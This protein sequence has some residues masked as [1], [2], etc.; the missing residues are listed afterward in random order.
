ML[1]YIHESPLPM[2]GEPKS[3]PHIVCVTSF[4]NQGLLYERRRADNN[5]GILNHQ[6]AAE[7]IVEHDVDE[8]EAVVCRG[9]VETATQH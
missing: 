4:H 7:H 8:D 1:N 9:L 5:T 6:T 3:V 2:C